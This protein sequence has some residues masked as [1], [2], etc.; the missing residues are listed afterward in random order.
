MP[1]RLV[2]VVNR[3]VLVQQVFAIA[4]AL[5]KRLTEDSTPELEAVREGLRALTGDPQEFFRVVELRG[6]IVANRDWAIRPTVPQLIIGTV[7][8]I[9]SRLLFQGYG[10]GKWGRPQQAGLL[11]VDSWVAV[12][13]A[14]LVPAFVLT[15]RQL[16][17]RCAMPPEDLPPP[18]DAVF[19]R[20]PFW[21]TELSATP[22]LPPPSTERPFRL[23]DD[24]ATDPAIAD[25]IL[26]SAKRRVEMEWLPKGEKPKEVLVQELV[27]A[28]AASKAVRTAVFVREVRVA[29]EVAAELWKREERICKITGRIRGYERDRLSEQAAFKAFRLERATNVPKAERHFLVGTAAAEVGLDADADVI[30]CDFASLPTLLQRLGRLDRRGVLTRRHAD[31]NGEP[32]RMRVFAWR[33]ATPPKIQSQLSKLA[34]ALKSDTAP[35]SAELIAGAHWLAAGNVT[36]EKTGEPK[37]NSGEAKQEKTSKG[38]T[39]PLIRAATWSVLNPAPDGVCTP[40]KDWLTRDL[41]RIASGPVV[42]P[43][44]TDAVLDYFSATTDSRSPHLSPHPF[45]YGLAED[46]E[47]TPLVGVAFRLEVEALRESTSDE[48]DM[49]TAHAA[50]EVLEIFNRFPPLRA[51]LHQV[52]LSAAREW[53]ASP[54]A[55]QHPF[56]YRGHDQWGAKSAGESGAGAVTALGP[57]ATLVLPASI[58]MRGQCKKLLEDC[59]QADGKNTAISDV[60]DGVS[61]PKWARYVRTIEPRHGLAGSQGAWLWNLEA[62]GDEEPAPHAKPNGFRQRLRKELRIGGRGFVFRYFRPADTESG[63]QFLDDHDGALGHLSRARDVAVRLAEAIAPGESFLGSLLSAAARHHDEGKRHQKWQRAFGRPKGQPEIAKLHPDLKNPAPLRGFRHEWESLRQLPR[64]GPMPPAELPPEA[65]AL[66]RDLFLHL[67]GAHHGH[68][69]P[70]IIDGGLDPDL[71]A[72]KQNAQRLEAAERFARLQHQLGHWRLAYLEALLKTADAEGS[73]YIPEDE[74]DGS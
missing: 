32:P 50:G 19:T 54:E 71:E 26:A 5:R 2:W 33:E 63:L 20:L 3:R 15:L 42:V 69:R 65:A 67:V 60:F 43:P 62:D 56:V 34:A 14:H 57:G 21:L 47:S 70:S 51:E 38:H 6:Q 41:A 13:E 31:G 37:Q 22:A 39:T 61:D 27:A 7:D 72:G 64:N 46:D 68:L 9:G 53:L 1:R 48:D 17:E 36:D 74:D 58:L 10:L 16:R 55:K 35:W 73:R 30:L 18:L 40:P 23:A 8:Q 28:A 11:G 12:D 44:V 52:S 66:W 49:E 4:E 29:N 59:E 25:R 45:L 24:E